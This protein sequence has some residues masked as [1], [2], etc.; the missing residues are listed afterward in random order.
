PPGTPC[1]WSC[2]PH[3]GSWEPPHTS[4]RQ[5]SKQLDRTSVSGGVCTWESQFCRQA[6]AGSRHRSHSRSSNASRPGNDQPG[7]T[8]LAEQKPPELLF[9]PYPIS[10]TYRLAWRI[11]SWALGSPSLCLMFSRYR[12]T[13]LGLR[14]SFWAISRV[15][16][17]CP[18]N[19][20]TCTSR[21]LR[22]AKGEAVERSPALAYRANNRC[23]EP[24][25]R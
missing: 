2:L 16:S 22:A 4:G 15:P 13:V 19:S 3:V 21:S 18:R 20:N 8:M 6:L 10:S 24:S 1:D 12:S 14:C 7:P 25:L 23:E 11:S 17:P 5:T 9:R